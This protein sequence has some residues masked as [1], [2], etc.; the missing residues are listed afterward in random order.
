MPAFDTVRE[1]LGAISTD[2]LIATAAHDFDREMYRLTLQGPSGRTATV[3]F[4][5][6]LLEDVRDN[7]DKPN[8]KYTIQITAKLD[9]L[10]LGTIES[11]GLISF[12]EESLKYALMKF[13]AHEQ[14]EGRE[15]HKYNVIGR[16]NDGQFE[17]YLRTRLTRA[18]KDTLIWTWDELIRLRLI[19]PTGKDLAQPDNW[20]KLT[21]RGAAVAE[22]KTFTE[23]A[24]I[25]IFVPQGG[26]YTAFRTLQKIFQ[27]AKSN[28]VVIDPYIDEQVLDHV[29]VTDAKIKV[30]ILTEHAKGLF[31]TAFAKLCQQRGNLEARVAREFHDRFVILD[32]TVCYQL[33]SSINHLGSKGTMIDRKSDAAMGQVLSEFA[34]TWQK[35]TAI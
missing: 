4:D 27:Q 7:P 21:E 25:E 33:G 18:E 17:Q 14:K 35:A 1:R 24:E 16:D 23:Y 13:V 9:E 28:I 8:A 11:C 20:I 3:E 12:G 34:K 15:L 2:I 19:A 32:G 22:G 26:V 31:K 6:E 30:Q 5:H 29:A 10:L